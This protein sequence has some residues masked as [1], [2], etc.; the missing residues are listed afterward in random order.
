PYYYDPMIAK[1]ICHAETR[2]LAIGRM[3]RAI[4]EFAISGL[5][6]TLSFC[7]FVMEHEAFTSG[8]FDT[9]FVERYFTPQAME[10]KGDATGAM[11]AAALAFTTLGDNPEEATGINI[12]HGS[13][14]SNWRRNR[15]TDR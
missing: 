6:T 14:G 15:S 4:D 12:S 2:E 11:I 8:H 1:L 9:H 10:G 5:E 13:P 7:K 3:I